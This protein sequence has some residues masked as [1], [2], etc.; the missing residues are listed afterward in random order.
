MPLTWQLLENVSNT[1][2]EVQRS[3]LLEANRLN[4]RTLR[5]SYQNRA[6]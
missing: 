6:S 4:K 1:I 5:Y 3:S 2:E